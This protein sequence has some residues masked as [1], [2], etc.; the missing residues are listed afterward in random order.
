[1]LDTFIKIPGKIGDVIW[2]GV[3]FLGTIYLFAMF[4]MHVFGIYSVEGIIDLHQ[5]L[6]F[7]IPVL[8]GLALLVN[9]WK[10]SKYFGK[11]LQDKKNTNATVNILWNIP[12]FSLG[13]LF[14]YFGVVAVIGVWALQSGYG[15]QGVNQWLLQVVP[16]GAGTG[17]GYFMVTFK[18]V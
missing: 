11:W 13:F 15:F 14:G 12:Q 8:F 5:I 9:A 10:Q 18:K 3:N 17:L 7:G 6:F 16:L 2:I 4:P 1:M